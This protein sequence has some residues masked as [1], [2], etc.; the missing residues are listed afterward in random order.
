[1]T[2]A[3]TSAGV[4]ARAIANGLHPTITGVAATLAKDATT[5]RIEAAVDRTTHAIEVKQFIATGILGSGS[6]TGDTPTVPRPKRTPPGL[7]HA[8]G[9]LGMTNGLTDLGYAGE[10]GGELVTILR[11]PKPVQSGGGPLTV[12]VRVDSRSVTTATTLASRYG[13]TAAGA[14]AQ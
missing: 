13:R 3:N 14:G 4:L 8:G 9:I 7:N 6:L 10:A 12:N 11:N 1:M 5:R 2:I